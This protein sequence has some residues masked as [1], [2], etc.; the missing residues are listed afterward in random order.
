MAVK[1]GHER[2]ASFSVRSSFADRAHESAVKAKFIEER[3]VCL[4]LFVHLSTHSK[5][6]IKNLGL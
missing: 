5:T 2:I 4:F 1:G 3:F 6:P